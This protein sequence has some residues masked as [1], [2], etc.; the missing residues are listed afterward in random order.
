MNVRYAVYY[1]YPTNPT[2]FSVATDLAF[3]QKSVP[4]IVSEH[5]N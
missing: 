4:A 1:H 5:V 2:C 3:T